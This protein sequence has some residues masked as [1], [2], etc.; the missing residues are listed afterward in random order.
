MKTFEFHDSD[1]FHRAMESFQNDLNEHFSSEEQR[2][3]Q[4]LR[5]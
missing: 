1:K 5:G 3:A 4:S 2:T